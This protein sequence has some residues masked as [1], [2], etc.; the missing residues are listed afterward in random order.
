[1]S[2][3]IDRN[4]PSAGFLRL[5]RYHQSGLLIAAVLITVTLLWAP[6]NEAIGLRHPLPAIH[7]PTLTEPTVDADNPAPL[8]LPANLEYQIRDGDTLS[9]LFD[10]LG[11]GQRVLYQILESDQSL[12]ALDT[13]QPGDRLRF[14]IDEAG[15]HLTRLELYFNPAHQVV[16]QRVAADAFEYHEVE[17]P[18]QWRPVPLNGEIHGSFYLSAHKAG[19]SAVE[20]GEIETIFKEKLNF[21][22]D[23]RAGDRF[24]VLRHE[25]YVDGQPSGNSELL[26]IRLFNRQRELGAF[27]FDDGNY[28]DQ[29]GRG[30]S[31][32]FLRY[33][34]ATSYRIS[35]TFNPRRKHPVT[36]RISPH[37]G[38]DFAT[39]KGTPVLATGDGIVSKTVNHP[40]A[41]KYIVIQHGGRYFTRYL[42]L[43]KFLVHK[44]EAVSRGQKI[45]LSGNTGRSTGPHLHYEFHIASKAV[46][47]M[48]AKIPLNIGVPAKQHKAFLA[49]VA[50]RTA[51]MVAAYAPADDGG[52]VAVVPTTLASR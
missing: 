17:V 32:A 2:A 28:Y 33:P 13:L 35:S 6:R 4:R 49:M 9:I 1:M 10:R 41:G 27:L 42:H 51:Q 38:V 40:Y 7:P 46:D 18:G 11:L 48:T 15:G 20:I 8:T 19:L 30:L 5:S 39:P 45:A 12:L 29:Q 31:R 34:T 47:P 37:N 44:G 23:L 52:D 22:R 25:H 21:S 43:S 14:W 24:E 26:A 50:Q 36:A 16:F 3:T